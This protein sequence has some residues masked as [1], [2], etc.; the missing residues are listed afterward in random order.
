MKS[1]VADFGCTIVLST[2]TQPA[3]NVRDALPQ[4]LRSVTE[5][6]TD[7]KRLHR[8]LR[9]V[10]VEWPPA[11]ETTTSYADIARDMKSHDRVLAIV[12]LRQDARVLA[13]QL[14]VDGRFHLSAL[15]CPAH[16]RRT[17]AAMT[18]A[19]A[20]GRVCRT[21]STQLVEAGVDIELSCCLP[22]ARRTR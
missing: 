19:L 12:H 16:R 3:L 11:D 13:E 14:P 17:L 9:R 1:L 5:I 2:A 22:G 10:R 15:M 4:G 21:V 8:A 20:E 6:A 7:P 18:R